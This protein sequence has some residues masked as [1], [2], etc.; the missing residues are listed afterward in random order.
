MKTTLVFLVSFLFLIIS[1]YSQVKGTVKKPPALVA[2]QKT[3][4]PKMGKNV[5]K[6]EIKNE[7]YYLTKE[8]SGYNIIGDYTYEDK[9]GEPIVKLNAD[10]TGLFQLHGMGKTPM[11]WGI[12]CEMNGIP[13]KQE[14]SF[15]AVYLL[16]YQIKERHKGKTRDMGEVDAWDAVQFSVRFNDRKLLIL[17]ERVKSY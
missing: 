9:G 2:T 11:E 1:S 7:T 17:G 15:G 13:K 12:E 3:T 16:W 4:T 14:G 10:G 6:V 8:I 5:T